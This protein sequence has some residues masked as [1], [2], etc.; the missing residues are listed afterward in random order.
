M[1]SQ[2]NAR[3]SD[4]TR[5]WNHRSGLLAGVM[6]IAIL[7]IALY[8]REWTTPST[9]KTSVA[10]NRPVM[11]KAIALGRLE[12]VGELIQVSAANSPDGNR[13]ARLLVEEGEEVQAGQNL[14]ILDSHDRLQAA[15]QQ[16]REQAAAARARLAQVK[17]GAKTGDILARSA[18]YQADQA[19]LD[20]QIVVQ[21]AAIANLQAELQ[22][23]QRTRQATSR[24][25]QAELGNARNDCQ[26]YQY[27]YE[28]GAVSVQSRDSTCLKAQTGQQLLQESQA[29]LQ[30]I[31]SSRSQQI[32][33][34]KA[35]LQRTID[36]QKKQILE[37]KASLASI[38][39]VRSVDVRVAEADLAVAEAAIK[40]AKANLE[41]AYVRAPKTGRILAIDT[42]EGEVVSDK[43]IVTL[44]QTQQMYAIA[45]VYESDIGK[46][47]VGQSALITSETVPDRLTGKVERVGLQVLKQN[48]INTDPSA[49]IDARVVEVKVR[50]DRASSQ[51]VAGLSNLQVLVTF[52]LSDSSQAKA[53]N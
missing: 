45:E 14:A 2:I 11:Q 27:L 26:R 37:A 7:P 8:W 52:D 17:A 9:P 5:P 19:E 53:R 25:L 31:V 13:L 41:R 30:R 35:N 36:T 39:E 12:P 50:L 4:S 24:R 40:E 43:G 34:A 10:P 28:N 46:I 51:K 49:N 22:G 29:D 1:A 32:L 44:G 33:E 3:S 23:E 48:V 16:A 6:A 20:G 42:R 47:H 18:K 21:R 38:S 15:L